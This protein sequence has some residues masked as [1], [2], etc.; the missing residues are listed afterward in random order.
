[1]KKWAILKIKYYEEYNREV[2]KTIN[3]FAKNLQDSQTQLLDDNASKYCNKIIIKDYQWSYARKEAKLFESR[4]NNYFQHFDQNFFISSE[5]LINS[6]DKFSWVSFFMWAIQSGGLK[7]M[8]A[9]K[10]SK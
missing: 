1:M 2:S 4:K 8:I 6:E 7:A 3:S 9:L 5:I 10:I